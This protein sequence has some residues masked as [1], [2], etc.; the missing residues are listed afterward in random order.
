MQ[1]DCAH[2]PDFAENEG[3]RLLRIVIG[4]MDLA[5]ELNLQPG[6]DKVLSCPI[7]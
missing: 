1:A 6:S 2:N 5:N 3:F 4:E 7:L